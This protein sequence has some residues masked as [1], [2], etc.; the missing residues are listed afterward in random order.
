MSTDKSLEWMLL[1]SSKG[2]TS[3]FRLLYEE[4]R[5]DIFRF[6]RYRVGTREDALDILQDTFL[7]LWVALQKKRFAYVS[8]AEFRGFLYTI[9]KRRVARFYRFRKITTS[10]D[11]LDVDLTE[12]DQGEVSH[13]IRSL[14]ILN[15]ED[16]E[17]V[18]LRYFEGLSFGEIAG[19]LD[20]EE[21]AVK[22]RHHRALAKLRQ[23]LD[24]EK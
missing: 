17:V 6:I 4:V 10:L 12:T 21:S 22:V 9:L 8:D 5:D 2:N 1:E 24:H 19:L 11:D 18:R 7:D 23:I 3:A 20:R 15:P 13:I 16:Q 14:E